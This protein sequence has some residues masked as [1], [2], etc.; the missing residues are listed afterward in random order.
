M[1]SGAS[2]L[3]TGDHPLFAELEARLA[4]LKGTEAALVFG[5][6]YLA[7]SGII[8]ALVGGATSS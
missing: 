5:S 7:N 4:R 8:P 6:G 2:R 3:V 1:G